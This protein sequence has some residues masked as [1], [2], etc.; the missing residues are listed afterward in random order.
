MHSVEQIGVCKQINDSHFL[1]IFLSRMRKGFRAT[2]A[3][4]CPHT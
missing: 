1:H 4:Q 2:V 3:E